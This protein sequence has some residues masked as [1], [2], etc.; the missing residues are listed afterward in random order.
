M[1]IV[2]AQH[3]AGKRYEWNVAEP[4][5]HISG[6]TAWIA[7]VNAAAS[8][9]LQAP[10]IN[11][12]WNRASSRNRRALGKSSLCKVL[13]SR[14]HERIENKSRYGTGFLLNAL[15]RNDTPLWRWYRMDQLL[16]W[17]IYLKAMTMESGPTRCS[18]RTSR[19]PASFIQLVQ[20][21]PV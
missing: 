1:A 12:G 19:K 10:C 6:N 3:V 7:Y 20:S 16:T 17:A 8:A 13:A 11:S 18:T 2:K 14:H 15:R 5:I 9:T 21:A 4:D